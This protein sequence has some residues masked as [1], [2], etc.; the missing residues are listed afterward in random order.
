MTACRAGR[1]R[2]FEFQCRSLN[3]GRVVPFPVVSVDFELR[4]ARIATFSSRREDVSLDVATKR[5]EA[6]RNGAGA[7]HAQPVPFASDQAESFDEADASG[8]NL[9]FIGDRLHLESHQI[10]YEQDP[11]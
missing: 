6:L 4:E 1:K 3:G 7:R 2:L 8:L 5:G 10:E 9:F 11:P